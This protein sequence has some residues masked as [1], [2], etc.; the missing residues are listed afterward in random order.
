MRAF[1]TERPRI[2][3]LLAEA[4]TVILRYFGEGTIVKLLVSYDPDGAEPPYIVAYIRT[5]APFMEAL[6]ALHRMEG[7]WLHG[8]S[9]ELREEVLCSLSHVRA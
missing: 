3:E 6:D 7:D 1:L 9:R 4:I 2:A 5:T 8:Y